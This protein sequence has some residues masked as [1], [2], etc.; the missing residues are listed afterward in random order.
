M[1]TGSVCRHDTSAQS[2]LIQEKSVLLGESEHSALKCSV[3][4]FQVVL[5]LD[6]RA[7]DWPSDVAVQWLRESFVWA[8]ARRS[9]FW[10]TASN[11]SS[12]VSTQAAAGTS[13][14]ADCQ[15]QSPKLR[16]TN[17]DGSSMPLKESSEPKGWGERIAALE[18]RPSVLELERRVSSV[19][20]QIRNWR[21]FATPSPS[22]SGSEG[23]LATGATP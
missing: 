3:C 9:N 2:T 20:A 23:G 4:S 8:Q 5:V 10:A 15:S 12:P 19:E 22:G 21:T 11:S 18:A 14:K 13:G 7:S 1:I 16:V 6:P 17:S